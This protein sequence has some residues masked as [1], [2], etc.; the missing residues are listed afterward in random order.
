MVNK[1]SLKD[2]ETYYK[3]REEGWA[4]IINAH[5]AFDKAIVGLSTAS[6]GFIFAFINYHKIEEKNSILIPFL[7]LS[8]KATLIWIFG[9]LILCIISILASFWFDQFYGQYMI[10]RAKKIYIEFENQYQNRKGCSYYLQIITKIISGISF[11]L[12]ITLFTI[13]FYTYYL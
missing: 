11:V 8:N 12:A 9:L 4:L 5:V 7:C 3:L 13:Y 1:T 2:H 6:L 10:F